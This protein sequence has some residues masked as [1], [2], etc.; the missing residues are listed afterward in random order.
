MKLRIADCG[1]RIR[2]DER[3]AEQLASPIE[4]SPT[5]SQSEIR[6]PQLS[7]PIRNPQFVVP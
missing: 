4:L 6:N 1:L 7:P 5:N 3:R 2:S